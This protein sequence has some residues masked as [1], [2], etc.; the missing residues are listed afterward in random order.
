MWKLPKPSLEIAISDIDEV[1]QKS[2]GQLSINDK[3]GLIELY[4]KYDL[5]S[6]DISDAD[7]DSFNHTKAEVIHKLYTKT[8]DSYKGEGLKFIRNELSQ[9]VPKCPYCGF[10]E[11]TTLDHYKPESRYKALSVCRLN[12]VPMCYKCNNLKTTGT[13]FV[14]PYYQVYPSGIQ[15]FAARSQFIFGY[16]TFEFYIDPSHLDKRLAGILTNQISI[17]QLSNR[18][19]KEAGEL[20]RDL[21]MSNVPERDDILNAIIES[22]HRTFIQK[23]G[24]NHWKS[25]V[26]ASLKN[27]A[28]FN[29]K[30]L[31]IYIRKMESQNDFLV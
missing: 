29:L 18:L 31:K 17:I 8:R 10:G 24:L 12:L 9:S 25:V 5:A 14:H 15:F 1:I 28:D 13:N 21:F 30:N 20:I 11:P 7:H 27:C 3:T 16:Y 6:G 26:T 2:N 23:Y 22:H 4:H 19:N